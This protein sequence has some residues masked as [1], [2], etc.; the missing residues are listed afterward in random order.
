MTFETNYWDPPSFTLSVTSLSVL[1]FPYQIVSVVLENYRS[2]SKEEPQDP[3]QN[4]WV[5]EVR[6]IEGHTSPSPEALMK[7]PS[8]KMIV[9]EKG[10]LN[11]AE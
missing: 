2:P 9:N 8:W 4:R 1:I 7:V 3:N 6:K 5:Q 11:V 10:E